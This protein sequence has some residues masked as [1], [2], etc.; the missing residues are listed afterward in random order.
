MDSGKASP[1]I[2]GRKPKQKLLEALVEIPSWV[3][4][5]NQGF[6]QWPETQNSF[7]I[8]WL[9]G[10][11]SASFNSLVW[12]FMC[13]MNG[14]ALVSM[15]CKRTVRQQ[16]CWRLTWD[17]AREK[18]S[19]V[20]TAPLF[21]CLFCVCDWLVGQSGGQL[22]LLLHSFIV[23]MVIDTLKFFI[24]ICSHH[25]MENEFSQVSFCLNLNCPTP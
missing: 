25:S 23:F 12:L 5:K 6:Y 3:W 24:P 18:L 16:G 4:P 14:F 15:S 19:H 2:S 8:S 11:L 17:T 1:K 13:D 21:F 10:I 22:V 9:T 7:H 20:V